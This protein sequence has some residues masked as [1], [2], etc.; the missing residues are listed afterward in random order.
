MPRPA[1]PLLIRY[2]ALATR[3]L[4]AAREATA[5]FWP[6]HTSTVL[7]PEAYSVVMNRALLGQAAVTYVDCTSRIRVISA[8][9]ATEYA[10]YLPLE[11]DIQIVADGVELTASPGR[12]L[13]RGPARTFVFEPSPLRGLVID[14]PAKVMAAVAGPARMLPRHASIPPPAATSL[15]RLAVRLAKA[16]D[17]SRALVALQRFSARDRLARL[18]DAI[19]QFE[20]EFAAVLVDAAMH[21]G[22]GD[23]CDVGALKRWLAGHA[24]RRVRV[25]ELA[26]RAGVSQRTVERAFLRTGCTPLAYLRRVRLDRARAMLVGPTQGVTVADVA[27]AVGYAHCGRFADEYRRHFGELPS[28]TVTRRRSGGK[29]LGGTVG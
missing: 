28:R 5:R 11:G 24:H 14:I 13:L 21:L 4:A 29:D 25:S 6:K 23:G 7:G 15:G 17:R 12:P 19:R 2:P 22:E 9:P 3:T 27:A 8:A 10:V 20:H 1:K 18:P 26:S 16:A